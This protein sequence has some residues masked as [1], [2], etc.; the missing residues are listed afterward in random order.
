MTDRQFPERPLVGVGAILFSPDLESVLLIER[1]HPPSVGAWTFPGG[2]VE[3]GE[4]AREACAREVREETGLDADLRGLALVAERV[5][6]DD[7]GRFEY[8]YLILDFWGVIAAEPPCAK[9]DAQNAR[10]VRLAEISTLSTT[11][12]VPEA[13]ARALALARGE[14]PAGP[15]FSE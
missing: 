1:G 10:W 7:A 2:L 5:V 4:T 6:K 15:I 12:G 3:R 8:H 14:A 9:T 13:L 11:R